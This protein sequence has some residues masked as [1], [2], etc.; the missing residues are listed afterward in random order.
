MFEIQVLSK[1]D[2]S[3]AL[4]MKQVIDVVESVYKAKSEGMTDVWPTV[5]YEFEPGKADLDIKSGYLKSKQLFGHKTVTWFGANIEKNL[6]TLMG[7]I[8]LFDAKTGMP[9][10]ITD[11]SYITGIRTGAAGALGAK[12]L[13][14]KTSEN[15]LIVGAGNQSAFQIAAALTVLPNIKKVQVAALELSEAESFV[16]NIRNRLQNEFEINAEDITFRAV[17]NLEVAVKESHIIITVTPS[18]KPIIKKDW[19]QKGTHISCIGA[20][21]EGKQEIDS[22]IMS[23]ALI[24]VDDMEHCKDVG[25]IEIPLKQG[26]ISEKNIIG[27][28]G[29]LIL[30]KVNGRAND[31]QITIFDATGM[32]LL[33]IATAEVAL[34]LAEK[35][36]LGSNSKL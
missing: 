8:A 35:N 9:I 26:V 17:E 4:K 22:E 14:R 20:D 18:R 21:M 25:E 13:A 15:L 5:F 24:F 7:M 31:E 28:I 34:Q 2:V 6:P 11:A 12:Y 10:G 36:K 16:A 1:E 3:K 27:E 33:D 19:V 32:A 30:N 29:D 23:S